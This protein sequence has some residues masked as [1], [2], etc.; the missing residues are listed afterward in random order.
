LNLGKATH[1]GRLIVVTN[2]NPAALD[3]RM[4]DQNL[5]RIHPSLPRC[6]ER[7]EARRIFE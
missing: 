3:D 4:L 1:D 6:A 7:S 2:A 5:R